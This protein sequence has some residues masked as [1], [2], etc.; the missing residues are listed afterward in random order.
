MVG[1]RIALAINGLRVQDLW[2]AAR[3]LSGLPKPGAVN[4]VGVGST[5]AS[6][7]FFLGALTLLCGIVLAGIAW[8]RR[9]WKAATVGGGCIVISIISGLL[10]L[11]LGL[12]IAGV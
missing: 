8:L 3:P 11:R 6:V 9:D 2:N 1:F 12:V 10:A 7:C 5:L 4:F